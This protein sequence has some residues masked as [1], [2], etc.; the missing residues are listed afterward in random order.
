M[1]QDASLECSLPFDPGAETGFEAFPAAPAVFAL[2]PATSAAAGPPY[3]GHTPN[4][5]RRLTKLLGAPAPA[6]RRLNLRGVTRRIDY[7]LTAPGFE[8]QWRL[9]ALNRAWYPSHYRRRLRLKPPALVKVKLR[10]R[11]PRCYATRRLLADG[12]LYYGPFPSRSAAEKFAAQF[13]DLFKMRRCVPDLDPDPA[14]P[15]CIYSQMKMCLAPCFKGCNDE[16]YQAETARVVGF[17]ESQGE[18]L[19]RE[20]ETE[21]EAASASLE[22]E[23]AARA[24]HKLEKV[25]DVARLRPQLVRAL[26]RLHAVM[27]LAGAAEKSVVFFRVT[28]GE[29]RGPAPLLLDE[30]V[31]SPVS[32]DQRIQDSLAGLAAEQ[33]RA[34]ESEPNS[35]AIGT[36]QSSGRLPPWEHLSLLA[37][38]Y[39]S[40]FRRGELIMLRDEHHIPHARLVRLCH[41]TVDSPEIK[42]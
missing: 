4:L 19:E 3:L 21:R 24:H 30:N 42:T 23:R 37:R 34:P 17:L 13:L 27:V 25:K 18:T 6:S 36:E 9:Y 26:P 1:R 2:F 33:P 8:A 20:L 39:Y 16:E 10:N 40:S 31:S 14:H 15:G 38:W 41:K 29:L 7:T 11:F 22:F 28:G 5:R 32:L 35:S 12:S